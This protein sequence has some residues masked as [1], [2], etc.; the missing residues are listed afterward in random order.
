MD[1]LFYIV[2][3]DGEQKI[4]H[5]LAEVFYNGS[6]NDNEDKDYRVME[7]TGQMFSPEHI[8]ELGT[9]LLDNLYQNGGQCY[10]GDLT[11]AEAQE[12][13]RTYFNGESGGS[14]L[15]IF[16]LTKDTPCG[17]YWCEMN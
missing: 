11:E 5:I 7:F 15:N 6:D 1:K 8:Q 2:E 17:E 14:E 10:L 16:K 9:G 12:L 3:T 4:T 13:C